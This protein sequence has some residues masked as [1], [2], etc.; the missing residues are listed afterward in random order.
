MSDSISQVE[1]NNKLFEACEGPKENI[2]QVITNL[3]DQGADVNATKYKYTLAYTLLRK[4]CSKEIIEL[5]ID[6]GF[7]INQDNGGS[8][9]ILHLACEKRNREVIQL[10][11]DK[12][13]DVNNININSEPPMI[14]LVSVY[15]DEEFEIVLAELLLK[16]GADVNHN[17]EDG[18]NL[19]H[20]ACTYSNLAAIKFLIDNG[21]SINAI[22]EDGNTPFHLI[23]HGYYTEGPLVEIAKLFLDKGMDINVKNN[24]GHTLLFTTNDFDLVS[25]LVE[26]GADTSMVDNK[27]QNILHFKVNDNF[28]NTNIEEYIEHMDENQMKIIFI[29][30]QKEKELNINAT[31]DEGNT[32]IHL[33]IDNLND[34][35]HVYDIRYDAPSFIIQLIWL[36]ADPYLVN[37]E[38][39][40]VLNFYANEGFTQYSNAFIQA[41][42]DYLQK[43]RDEIWKARWPLMNVLTGNKIHLMDA[44]RNQHKQI[45]EQLDK[46]SQIS[47][48]SRKTKLENLLY[49]NNAV[50]G[51]QFLLEIIVKFIPRHKFEFDGL[52]NPNH[53]LPSLEPDSKANKGMLMSDL[54]CLKHAKDSV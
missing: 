48:I 32:V 9:S 24:D 30:L 38:G 10:L 47:S 49:L 21:A 45:K 52:I 39:I 54:N 2:L 6:R 37:K 27:G 34:N 50:F 33:I 25:F 17:R 23:D 7:D 19:L 28:L 8:G 41:H 13:A 14:Q 43:I 15:E 46:S 11:I 3:L 35:N 51:D 20:N 4:D 42:Q 53:Y 29:L 1:L 40:S 18:R 22:D 31:T 16:G 5:L 44:V 36:G 12:G 26:N